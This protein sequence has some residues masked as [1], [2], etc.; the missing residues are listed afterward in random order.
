[1]ISVICVSNNMNVLNEMLKKSLQNQ[2]ESYELVVLENSNHEYSS[3]ASALNRGAQKAIGDI[4][5]FAHQDISFD[6]QDFLKKIRLYLN[7]LPNN[8]LVGLAGIADEK[9]VVSNLKQGPNHALAGPI[10]INKPFEVQTLDEVLIAC[11]KN[12]FNL[13]KF[14]D[15]VCDDW[16]LYGVDFSLTSIALGHKNYVLPLEIFHKSSGKISLGYALTLNKVINKHRR[17]VPY[18]YT[19]CGVS[20][21][22]YLRSKQYVLGLIWDHVIKG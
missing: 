18:I 10:Q 1:M 7:D 9:G 6:D 19:T 11:K 13:I 14:D 5:V 20:K 15:K 3:A 12:T 4:L 2:S 22:S 16:H 17:E 21:T 8:S